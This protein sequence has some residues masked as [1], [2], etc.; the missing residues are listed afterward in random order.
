M[1]LFIR[2]A[3]VMVSLH[4]NRNPDRE[5]VAWEGWRVCPTSS[6]KVKEDI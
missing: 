2:V 3:V 4:S 6:S 1:L 5:T